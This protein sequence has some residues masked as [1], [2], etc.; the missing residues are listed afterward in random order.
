MDASNPVGVTDAP[1][2]F[3]TASHELRT[4]LTGVLGYL[5]LVLEDEHLGLDH[6]RHL[7]IAHRCGHRLL[8]AVEELLV[9]HPDPST[10]ERSA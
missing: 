5:E 3:A 7:E 1:D 6:R 10:P 9:P 8:R 2:F 4:P